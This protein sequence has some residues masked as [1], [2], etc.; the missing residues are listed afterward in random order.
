MLKGRGVAWEHTVVIFLSIPT[1]C[2]KN[3]TLL[4]RLLLAFGLLVIGLPAAQGQVSIDPAYFTDSTPITITFDATQGS[5][6]LATYTGDVYIYT[7]V[8]T[9]VSTSDTNWRYVVNSSYNAPVAAEKMTALGNHK[10]SISIT[11]R[12]YY[13]GFAASGETM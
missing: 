8:I 10:Y 9:N 5:G 12:S 13:P 4:G 3:T 6:G 7:G 2:M 1:H 11:P